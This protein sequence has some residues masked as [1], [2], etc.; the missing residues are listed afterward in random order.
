MAIPKSK[1][2]ITILIICFLCF[3]L[4]FLFALIGIAGGFKFLDRSTLATTDPDYNKGQCCTECV[5]SPGK[6][7]SFVFLV[8]LAIFVVCISISLYAF[9]MDKVKKAGGDLLDSAKGQ[10]GKTAKSV[11]ELKAAQYLFALGFF[12]FALVAVILTFT[13]GKGLYSTTDYKNN[14]PT[15]SPSECQQQK[16][17]NW[18]IACKPEF[19]RMFLASAGTGFGVWVIAT[20]LLIVSK[21]QAQRE[22][23]SASYVF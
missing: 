17:G 6:F 22:A 8:P 2:H 15:P 23:T 13:S 4:F 12:V 14:N 16:N 9:G 20:I 1:E 3:F 5:E 18:C 21:R 19:W 10:A 11:Q 7:F